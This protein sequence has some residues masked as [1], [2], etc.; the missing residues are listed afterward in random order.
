VK[1]L[2]DQNLSPSLVARLADVFPESLHVRDAGLAR[3]TDESVW[4]FALH[5]G[6]AIVTKDSDFQEHSQLAYT[7]PRVAFAEKTRLLYWHAS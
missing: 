3:A 2:F 5:R 1:L 6:F 7:A 4:Q